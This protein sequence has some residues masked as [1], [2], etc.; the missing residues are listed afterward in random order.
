MQTVN[1][2]DIQHKVRVLFFV[3]YQMKAI[4]EN[5]FTFD[6]IVNLII[7]ELA[8]KSFNDLELMS[9]G[10]K[11]YFMFMQFDRAYRFVTPYNFRLTL[12]HKEILKEC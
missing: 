2:K 8:Q 3:Y 12:Y 5:Y 4:S 10:K 7:R 6:E 11:L 1:F 9:L